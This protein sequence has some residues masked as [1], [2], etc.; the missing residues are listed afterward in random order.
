M[1]ARHAIASTLHLFAVVAF[2][3]AGV[4][5]FAIPYLPEVRVHL[6]DFLLSRYEVSTSI[7][8]GF[9]LATVLLFSGFYGLNRGRFLRIEMGKHSAGVGA[10][11]IRQTLETFFKEQFPGRIAVSDVEIIRAKKLEIAVHLAAPEEEAWEE[12]FIEVE[13]ALQALLRERFGYSRPFALIVK[14]N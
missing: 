2:F 4:F 11:A 9:F 6:A 3:A 14:N 7:A 1:G 13:K 5:F 8:F 10:D 12:L